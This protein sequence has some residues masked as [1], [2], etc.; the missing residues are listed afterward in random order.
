MAR[1]RFLNTSIA[2]DMALNQLSIEAH[3]LYMM[4]IPHLDRDGLIK[5]DTYLLFGKVCPRRPELI[6]R[7]DDLVDEWAKSGLVIVYPTRDGRV[8]YFRGFSKN[9][10][11]MH[12]SREAASTLEPPP[13]HVRAESGIEPIQD[14]V[15]DEP[16]PSQSDE[17]PTPDEIRMNSGLTPAEVKYEVKGEGESVRVAHKSPPRQK[18]R[19]ELTRD[20]A[21]RLSAGEFAGCEPR[22]LTVLTNAVK[23][24]YG[25]DS[26]I[27][28]PGDDR[29]E[30][31]LRR[32]AYRL[33]QTG[34]Q[35]VQ[36]MEM[37]A[38]NWRTFSAGF[39]I[40][41]PQGD[42]LYELAVS[43]ANR[44]DNAPASVPV[45]GKGPYRN[46]VVERIEG[47]DW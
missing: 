32:E 34:F 37:L 43:L 14:E 38:D 30:D 24:I 22:L 25:Y 35:D 8:A 20:R 9:Q 4:T 13:N 17:I 40:K 27:E 33:W 10:Q 1:G 16:E 46:M 26:L 11:G 23:H 42:Q 12:Y 19:Q 7:I 15:M 18:T 29:L 5:A 41:R 2:E 3:W 28:S 21:K 39:K 6:G 36:A 44:V 47:E 45:N 31:K